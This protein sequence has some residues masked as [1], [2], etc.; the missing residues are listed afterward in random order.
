MSRGVTQRMAMRQ[1]LQEAILQAGGLRALS[2]QLGI[3]H[4]AILRWDR[5][6]ALRVLEIERLTGV[7]RYRLRPDVY[8]PEP[9]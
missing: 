8:G 3:G 9:P 5:A 1:A 4:T 2:R 7:S 6:P